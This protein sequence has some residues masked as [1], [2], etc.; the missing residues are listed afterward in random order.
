MTVLRRSRVESS[1]PA[2]SLSLLKIAVL[3]L[4]AEPLDELLLERLVDEGRRGILLGFAGQRAQLLLG[5]DDRLHGAVAGHDRFED[6][7]LGQLVGAG[8][9]HEH[10]VRVP[11]T[12]RSSC[13]SSCSWRIVGLTTSLPSR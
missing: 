10:R 2:L 5:L 13:D 11:A 3:E 1:R 9:D 7:V 8:L 12:V 6:Q 4:F